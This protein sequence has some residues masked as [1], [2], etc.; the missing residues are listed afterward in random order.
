MKKYLAALTVILGL[1]FS[2]SLA[3]AA[4]VTEWG[5]SVSGVFGTDFKNDTNGT[6][7][8]ISRRDNGTTL[9]WGDNP[10]SSIHME[11]RSGV[12]YTNGA[13]ARGL[14]LSH[15]NSPIDTD[16]PALRYGSA[17][18]SLSLTPLVPAGPQQPAFETTLLFSFFETTNS[19][20]YQDDIFVVL[21]IASATDRFTYGG[22]EYEFSFA[23]S[24]KNL[25]MD[26]NRWYYDYAWS[27]LD[28]ASRPEYG[29]AL[30]GWVTTERNDTSI[31]TW[32]QIKAVEKVPT[33]E[34]GTLVL[35]G[36]GLLG[37][38]LMTWRRRR[39]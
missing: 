24:F 19:G 33:P 15:H 36:A 29:V 23:P 18:L 22:Q 17:E 13:A 28:R 30:Y 11:A 20:S 12:A 34:P 5:Y 37:V 25:W 27:R 10:Y 21:D 6:Q 26:Y 31:P 3:N 4:L 2:A 16:S 8:G 14:D 32:F 39:K 35:M 9:R 38:G 7:Q 1:V